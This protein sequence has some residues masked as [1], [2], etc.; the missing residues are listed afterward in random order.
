LTLPILEVPD[1]EEFKTLDTA[2]RLYLELAAIGAE[3]NTPI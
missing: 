3:R 2:G 1:G